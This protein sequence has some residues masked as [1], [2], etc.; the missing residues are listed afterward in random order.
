VKNLVVAKRYARALF[1]LAL[2]QDQVEPYGQELDRFVQLLREFPDL[3]NAVQN[4]LYPEAPRRSLCL[5][6]ADKAELGPIIK[7]FIIL[8][9]EKNRVGHLAEI[10][11]YYHKL[12]DDHANIARAKVKAAVELDNGAI[13]KIAASLEQL[14]GKKIAIEFER[15]P[16]LIGGVVAQIGDLVL[17]GSV[18]RQLLNIK[19]TLKRGELG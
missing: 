2:E 11:E 10:S 16:E 13:Q 14:T 9:V 1:S 7:N 4:P 3:A 17:D 19:E 18:R 6:V 5:S 12:I 8:L 15:D